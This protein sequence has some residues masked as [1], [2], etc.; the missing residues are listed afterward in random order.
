MD[1]FDFKYDRIFINKILGHK[2]VIPTTGTKLIDRF[3]EGIRNLEYE[4]L[5]E[6]SYIEKVVMAHKFK[7][8]SDEEIFNKIDVDTINKIERKSILKL[9]NQTK[10]ILL[11]YMIL[12]CDNNI[13]ENE[14][15][16]LRQY[17]GDEFMEIY[18]NNV[19]NNKYTSIIKIMRSLESSYGIV[20]TNTQKRIL[21]QYGIKTEEELA[22]LNNE[23]KLVRPYSS[24]DYGLNKILNNYDS[25]KKDS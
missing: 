5:S 11:K 2:V 9:K 19:V 20:L 6:L 1:E 17:F 22:K 3:W 13:E 7:F 10:F 12:G 15:M 16:L 18:L 14:I 4:S 23:R 21:N 25:R 8:E 24:K